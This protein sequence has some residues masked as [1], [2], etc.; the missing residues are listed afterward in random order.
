MFGHTKKIWLDIQLH[1]DKFERILKHRREILIY[2]FK[3]TR[4]ICMDI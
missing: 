1:L 3:Y 2:I 4:P